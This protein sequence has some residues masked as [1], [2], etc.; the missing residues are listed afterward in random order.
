MRHSRR[1]AD[2]PGQSFEH[3]SS[4]DDGATVPAGLTDPFPP[5]KFVWAAM[6]ILLRFFPSRDRVLIGRVIAA[7]HTRIITLALK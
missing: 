7:S 2:Q 3:P 1:S 4:A 6:Q 5:L